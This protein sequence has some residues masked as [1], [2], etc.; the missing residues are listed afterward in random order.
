M[1]SQLKRSQAG[2]TYD[3]E[4]SIRLF[5]DEEHINEKEVH[6][7]RVNESVAKDETEK[8]F[9]LQDVVD[10]YAYLAE[11]VKARNRFYTSFMV[12]KV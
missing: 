8:Q 10:N 7:T 12:Y 5:F 4:E 6:L 2:S 11:E 9:R 3:L 1:L